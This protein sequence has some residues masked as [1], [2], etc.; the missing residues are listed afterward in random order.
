MEFSE[1]SAV[2]SHQLPIAAFQDH[3]L[4][5]R[6]FADD[7]AQDTVLEACLRSALAVIE[8]RTD[9]ALY[10]RSFVYKLAAWREPDCQPLPVA[11]VA[12]VSRVRFVPPSGAATTVDADKYR[13]EP[14]THRP[15]LRATAA[16]LPVPPSGSTIEIDL[17]AGLAYGWTTMPADLA[18]AVLMLAAHHYENRS[19]S[20]GGATLADMPHGVAALI[21]RHRAIR[22]MGAR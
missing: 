6:G 12:F 15:L 13:L 19:A 14:D 1:V 20:G 22:L 5:G 18:Q 8:G 7:G 9:K 17:I 16:A 21:E 3:L 11:P 10:R 4:L 2:P